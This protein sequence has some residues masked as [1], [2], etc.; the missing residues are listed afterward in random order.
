MSK[1]QSF[2]NSIQELDSIVEKME[3]GQLSLEESLELFEK[4]VQ[5]TRSCQKILSDAES[6][7]EKLM[8]EVA[9]EQKSN[10]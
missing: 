3:S 2:E 4:G 6:K 5:L 9:D 1:K 7:I 8:K 10:D